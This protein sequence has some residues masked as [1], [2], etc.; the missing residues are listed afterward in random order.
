MVV[1]GD[2]CQGPDSC[3][4]DLLRREKFHPLVQAHTFTNISTKNPQGSRSLDNIWI[5]KSFKKVFTGKAK[6]TIFLFLLVG[7]E[8]R[9]TCLNGQARAL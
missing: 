7:N 2:F 6:V 1:L 8:G 4:H 3:D 5:S 9:E